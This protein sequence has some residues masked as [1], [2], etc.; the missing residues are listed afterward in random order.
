MRIGQLFGRGGSEGAQ[1]QTSETAANSSSQLCQRIVVDADMRQPQDEICLDPN[2][3]HGLDQGA[4]HP[5]HSHVILDF[6][7]QHFIEDNQFSPE[8]IASFIENL[9]NQRKAI[10]SDLRETA[11]SEKMQTDT[12]TYLKAQ[13]KAEQRGVEGDADV[14]M[15]FDQFVL[16]MAQDIYWLAYAHVAQVFPTRAAALESQNKIMGLIHDFIRGYAPY[17]SPN[18]IR[19][20]FKNDTEIGG[21]AKNALFPHKIK[22]HD[23]S[24][25]EASN[26]VVDA[27]LRHEVRETLGRDVHEGQYLSPTDLAELKAAKFDLSRLMPGVSPFWERPNSEAFSAAL[28]EEAKQFPTP[29][30]K[31]TYKGPRYRSWISTKMSATFERDGQKHLIKIK[32]GEEAHSDILTSYLRR[33]MGFFQD[34]MQHREDFTL[35]L[36][37]KTYQEFER[38]IAIKYGIN[39]LKQAIVRRGA[40]PD[41]GEE[42]VVFKS[43]ALELRPESDIRAT[44]VDAAVYDGINRRELRSRR[45]LRAFLGLS[46]IKPTNHRLVFEKQAN[47]GLRPQYR[48][49]DPGSSIGTTVLLQRPRD[50][51]RFPVTKNKIEEYDR[52]YVRVNRKGDVSIAFNDGFYHHRDDATATYADFK[53]MARVIGGLSDERIKAGIVHAGIPAELQ[54]IYFYHIGNMKNRALKA[55]ELVNE[56]LEAP[57]VLPNQLSD[58]G[59]LKD[60]NVPGFVEKGKVTTTYVPNR[61]MLPKLQQ[62]WF[63]FLNG[64]AGAVQQD[65][66]KTIQKKFDLEYQG[67]INGIVKSDSTIQASFL[68]DKVPDKIAA[69]ALT[70]GVSVSVHRVVLPNDTH[71]NAEGKGRPY[72]V[73]DTLSVEIGVEASLF[74]TLAQIVTPDVGAKLKFFTL[75]LSHFHFSEGVLSGYKT[76]LGIHKLLFGNLDR[77]ALETLGPGE[78]IKHHWSLGVDSRLA[79][80]AKLQTPVLPVFS[81][82]AGG[83]AAL[84]WITAGEQ[85]YAKDTLGSLH[86]IQEHLRQRGL[87]L[88]IDLGNIDVR[89][90]SGA[91]L[92]QGYTY[93]DLRQHYSDIEIKPPVYDQERGQAA[94]SEY[95]LNA[96]QDWLAKARRNPEMVAAQAD[97]S[98]G[99]PIVEPVP[100]YMQLHY[101]VDAHRVGYSRGNQFLFA[102][103]RSRSKSTV[104]FS[105]V[106]RNHAYRFRKITAVKKGLVGIE[107][108][109]I[110]FDMYNLLVKTGTSKKLTIEMD[111]DNPK[112]FV[113]I[114]DVYDYKRNLSRDKLVDFIGEL[115][116]RYSESAE[117]PFFRTDLLPS[118]DDYKKIYANGRIYIDGQ[119]LLERLDLLTATDFEDVIRMAYAERVRDDSRSAIRKAATSLDDRKIARTALRLGRR[120]KETVEAFSDHYA[121]RG[122]ALSDG[123][124]PTTMENE[125]ATAA[126]DL[127]YTL[128]KSKFG[129]SLLKAVLGEESMLM[130]GEIYG[131][132][133]QT[134][135]LQDDMWKSTQRFMGESYGGGMRYTRAP[136]QQYVRHEQFQPP[137]DLAR[138]RMEIEHFLGPIAKGLSGE[139]V[140]LGNR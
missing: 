135:M 41:T 2:L 66:S 120:L 116:Q 7:D 110:D 57:S 75:N 112:K 73:R 59:R 21:I 49:Q 55:F 91:L 99:G 137:S 18:K 51:L 111:R 138:P 107:E 140:G 8:K 16:P 115:N 129:V 77:Y 128:Y 104:D 42:W 97:F 34:K 44:T 65:F 47:G 101:H 53:W 70:P 132:H 95:D 64:L 58:I 36:G 45:L 114:L 25:V 5:E 136:V 11:I 35:H 27:P 108:M 40:D 130:I 127:I 76:G 43:A 29:Q 109:A 118:E 125:L 122:T 26:L 15:G 72:L 69:F 23:V 90:L 113:G 50:L 10:A 54:S 74:K 119:V 30:E 102:F 60:I 133:Q 12:Q 124:D 61:V 48:F 14:L 63:T 126:F 22:K 121:R 80:F 6:I 106:S 83:S 67:M 78:A 28:A 100:D 81:V 85:T 94:F 134:G 117:K 93:S 31:V 68:Q 96:A 79:A 13:Q 1:G 52:D 3:I 38:D 88:L 71:F 17:Y 32:V 87:D 4:L 103:D 123:R 84:S 24:A 56:S 89:Q 139:Y 62:T 92:K 9:Q 46:D 131:I 105:T 37:D 33:A 82:R 98:E 86:L 20:Y 19:T 39:D